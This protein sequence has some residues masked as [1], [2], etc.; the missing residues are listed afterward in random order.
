MG[1][2]PS[3]YPSPPSTNETRMSGQVQI[4]LKKEKDKPNATTT[5]LNDVGTS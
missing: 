1:E 2:L 3:I 4:E 5:P